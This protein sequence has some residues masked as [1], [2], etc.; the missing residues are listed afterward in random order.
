MSHF[1]RLDCW[2]LIGLAEPPVRFPAGA[3]AVQAFEVKAE[4]LRMQANANKELSTSLA[5]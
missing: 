3:D 1:L 2:I 4:L 5:L